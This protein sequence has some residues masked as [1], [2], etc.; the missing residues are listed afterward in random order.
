[1]NKTV[2][3][4]KNMPPLTLVVNQAQAAREQAELPLPLTIHLTSWEASRWLR[5]Y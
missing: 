2:G 1:M 4:R 5:K 3:T